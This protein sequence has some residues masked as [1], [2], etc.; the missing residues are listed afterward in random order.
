MGWAYGLTT[1]P[2]RRDNLFLRTLTSLA[3]AGFDQPRLFIDGCKCPTQYEKYGLEVTT[4]Y[5]NL[6]TAGNWVLSLYELYIRN[7]EA[8]RFAIFQDDFVTGLN[9]RQYLDCCEYPE[10]GYWN[11]YTFPANQKLCPEG[12]TYQGWYPADQY[13]KGAVA[14]VFNRETVCTLLSQRM[15]V[16]RPQDVNR[17]HKAIDGGIVDA[18]SP[19]G[20]VEY[21]HNPS[22]VQHTGLVSSM[23][24]KRHPTAETFPGENFDFMDLVPNREI[25]DAKLRE[26][27]IERVSLEKA[28]REDQDRANAATI[29]AERA[30]FLS[31]VQRY[32]KRLVAHLRNYHVRLKK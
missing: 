13:G 18:L 9:L 8:D 14:L 4:H 29:P 6:R 20:F 17:G 19:L 21:V 1:V 30:R 23:S 24:N 5:P 10:Q 12:K 3:K 27:E 31:H 7:P 26:W 11:L 28:M 32:Q 16:N 2:E 22:L 15:L 25:I